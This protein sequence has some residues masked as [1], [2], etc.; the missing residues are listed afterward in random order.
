MK[1][2]QTIRT[3]FVYAAVGGVAAGVSHFRPFKIGLG[4][5]EVLALYGLLVQ[6]T[7]TVADITTVSMW[8]L[9]QKGEIEADGVVPAGAE[10]VWIGNRQDND[11]IVRGAYSIVALA[12][13]VNRQNWG[14]QDIKFPEPIFV[15]RSPTMEYMNTDANYDISYWT[16]LFYKKLKASPRE[17]SL[18]LKQWVG[19]KQNVVS[20]IPP[21]IDE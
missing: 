12:G 3:K 11:I 21:T 16:T 14:P 15:P 10:S 1:I 5:D 2:L 17:I 8:A 20:N 7:G 19:R 4:P 6:H 18:L 9:L 13:N